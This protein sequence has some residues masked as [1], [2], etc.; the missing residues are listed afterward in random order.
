MRSALGVRHQ[1]QV[2][3][4]LDRTGECSL[5][6]SASACDSSGKNLAALGDILAKLCDVL[7]INGIVLAAEHANFS[8]SME[9]ASLSER[10]IRTILS[11][12]SPLSMEAASLSERCIRTILSVKSH[13]YPPVYSL[14]VRIDQLKGSSSSMPSGMFINPS[15]AS[16]AGAVFW[17]GAL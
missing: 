15:S 13:F 4:S 8:L 10:C 6:S 3:C 16:D 7:V 14:W 11:V 1:S 5:V 9:A 12:K 17:A 2:A